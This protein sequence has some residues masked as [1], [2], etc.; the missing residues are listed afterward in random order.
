MTR[1]I[2]YSIFFFAF[3]SAEKGRPRE[4]E[5][6]EIETRMIEDDQRSKD[7]DRDARGRQCN[8]QGEVGGFPEAIRLNT[9]DIIVEENERERK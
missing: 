5:C 4:R 3:V 8:G 2:V 1:R 9:L 7:E 6:W